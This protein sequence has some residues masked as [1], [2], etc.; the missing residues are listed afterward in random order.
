M[1][2]CF[3]VLVE[4]FEPSQKMARQHHAVYWGGEEHVQ[5][6]DSFQWGDHVELEPI[7]DPLPTFVTER[8]PSDLRGRSWLRI[9]IV[10]DM[11]DYMAYE[12]TGGEVDW[13]EHSPDDLIAELL[14]DRVSWIA[15]FLMNAAVRANSLHWRP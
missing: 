4:R 6:P 13:G 10:G 1:D 2:A 5:R 14:D 8:L 12:A 7:L 15:V 11:L 3:E 9:Q